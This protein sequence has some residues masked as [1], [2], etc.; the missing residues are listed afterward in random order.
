MTRIFDQLSWK[1]SEKM[2]GVQKDASVNLY[3]N[4]AIY[5]LKL[6]FNRMVA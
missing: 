6:S 1:I 5:T 3:M 2:F 4:Y